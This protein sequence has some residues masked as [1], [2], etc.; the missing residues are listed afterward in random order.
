MFWCDQ[1]I[2]EK[3]NSV[4]G[5]LHGFCILRVWMVREGNLTEPLFYPQWVDLDVCYSI[6]AGSALLNIEYLPNTCVSSVGSILSWVLQRMA[7]Y[8]APDALS[9]IER[10][11]QFHRRK[12][13]SSRALEEFQF[14]PSSPPRGRARALNRRNGRHSKFRTRNYLRGHYHPL[15][16][17]IT[18]RDKGLFEEAS[19]RNA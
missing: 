6:D 4:N 7:I 12:Y 15:S 17:T 16:S 1:N 9:S 2:Y 13:D 10:H 18:L 8:S 11:F 19:A 14:R 3:E 5:R